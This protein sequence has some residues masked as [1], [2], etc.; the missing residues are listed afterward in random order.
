VEGGGSVLQVQSDGVPVAE[1]T[2]ADGDGRVDGAI[3]LE[4]L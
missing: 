1:L 2:D 4:A 3:L